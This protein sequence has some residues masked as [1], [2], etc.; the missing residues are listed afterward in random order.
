MSKKSKQKHVKDFLYLNL[1]EVR[2]FT[3]T[4]TSPWTIDNGFNGTTRAEGGNISNMQ[5]LAMAHFTSGTLKV[6]CELQP[7]AS[8]KRGKVIVS[9]SLFNKLNVPSFCV[10]RCCA[11]I[12]NQ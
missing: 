1:A 4:Q 7:S 6:V 8:Q 12:I 3:L 11:A 2:L 9:F 5:D 10:V